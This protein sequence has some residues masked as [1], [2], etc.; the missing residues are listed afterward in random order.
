MGRRHRLPHIIPP[1]PQSQS[2]ELSSDMLM[3]RL[4]VGCSN[5]DSATVRACLL[6]RTVREWVEKYSPSHPPPPHTLTLTPPNLC[7]NDRRCCQ[8]S[9]QADPPLFHDRGDAASIDENTGAGYAI[10]PM[11]LAVDGGFLK[12]SYGPLQHR[13]NE[14]PGDLRALLFPPPVTSEKGI[15]PC[16]R[17][18]GHCGHIP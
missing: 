1:K 5:G 3:A 18:R 10:S 15:R 8:S 4:L 9:D 7:P 12:V 13:A 14:R 2:Q 6:R 16:C 17:R 11:A